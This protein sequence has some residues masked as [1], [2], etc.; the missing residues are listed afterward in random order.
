[1]LLCVFIFVGCEVAGAGFEVV[2]FVLLGLWVGV[3]CAY[4]HPMLMA[5]GYELGGWLWANSF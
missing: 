5:G 4:A 3:V 2:A 1:M